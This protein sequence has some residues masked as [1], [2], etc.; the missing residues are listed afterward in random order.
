MELLRLP[1]GNEHE[2]REPDQQIDRA[3]RSATAEVGGRITRRLS[4]LHCPA[5]SIAAGCARRSP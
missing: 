3:G 1:A 5:S 2:R 4:G